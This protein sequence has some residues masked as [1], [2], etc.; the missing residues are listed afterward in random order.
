MATRP[1][2]V[3]P[4]EEMKHIAGLLE[5][6]LVQWP[7]VSMRS[8]FG[9]RACYRGDAIFAV[10]PDKRAM[11]NPR[12]IGYRMPPAATREKGKKWQTFEV[13]SSQDIDRALAHLDRAY[14]KAAARRAP[15]R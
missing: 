6:E 8:M 15:K 1:K 2:L 3:R 14:R 11:S 7:D 9:M 5:R 12:A 10:L 13:E 4:S